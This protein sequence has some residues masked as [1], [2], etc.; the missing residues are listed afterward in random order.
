MSS[1]SST[2]ALPEP[3][4][5]PVL[6]APTFVRPFPVSI[7]MIMVGLCFMGNNLVTLPYITTERY[8]LGAS[9]FATVSTC[10]WL[11]TFFSNSIFLSPEQLFCTVVI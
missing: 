10:F 6:S 3:Q 2:S 7:S 1:S 4:S 5:K 11:G 8:G 9:G